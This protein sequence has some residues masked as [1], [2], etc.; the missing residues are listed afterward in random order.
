MLWVSS[1]FEQVPNGTS[2]S[3]IIGEHLVMFREVSELQEQ[4]SKLLSSLRE[5]TD[6]LESNESAAIE[7]RT[8]EL[9]V[10]SVVRWLT[11]REWE[12]F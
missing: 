6:K 7:A 12:F 8:Q 5:M 1:V 2:A 3:D 11:S 4:N 10:H 9:K